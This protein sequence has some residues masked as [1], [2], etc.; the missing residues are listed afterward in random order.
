M[1][2]IFDEEID[3][4]PS[5]G[6]LSAINYLEKRRDS[7]KKEVTNPFI[8]Y[9]IGFMALNIISFVLIKN[10]NLITNITGKSNPLLIFGFFVVIIF[11]LGIALK[12]FTKS[13][14][15]PNDSFIKYQKIYSE[16]VILPMLKDIDKSFTYDRDGSLYEKYKDTLG[17]I[18]PTKKYEDLVSA[19]IDGIEFSLAEYENKTDDEDAPAKLFCFISDFNKSI[20]KSTIIQPKHLSTLKIKNHKKIDLDNAQ[21]N[22]K[23]KVF[24]NDEVE[25]RYIL[26]STFM[27]RL[28][29]MKNHINGVYHF[30]DNKLVFYGSFVRGHGHRNIDLFDIDV[31][32]SIY[33]QTRFN[34][35]MV[36]YIINFI[37][38]LNLDS[39]IWK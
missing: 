23:F 31:G 1:S 10:F 30:K 2:K 15:K 39:K 5:K 22:D 33:S 26:T 6:V 34:Y 20:Y 19:N 13:Y 18:L 35:E 9:I 16:N 32:N 12:K 29:N 21:F 3:F 27:E 11:G 25:S 28:L 38:E 37:N 8:I 24:S 17:D 36:R 7:I 14:T 4:K